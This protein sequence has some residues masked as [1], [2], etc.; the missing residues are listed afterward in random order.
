MSEAKDPVRAKELYKEHPSFGYMMLSSNANVSP[1]ETQI[2][3]Q[4]HENQDGTG[5]PTGLRGENLPP[6][7]TVDRVQKGHI[8]RLAE[9]CS[10][11]NA[12]DNLA[13]NPTERTPRDSVDAIRTII[14]K[15]GTVYNKDVVKTLLSVVPYY[16]VGTTVKVMDIVDPALVGAVGVVAK[17]HDDN[18]NKP[19][20]IL[21]KNK[22]M[23]KIKPIV[24]DTSQF[25]KVSLKLVV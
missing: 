5:F 13:Y 18:I 23:K 4:H 10:V 11:A 3:N 24:L 22:F 12:F 9:V 1:I 15:A 2:V 17:L 19:I 20:I 8:F 25:Q 14:L 7:K 16:P 6:V 21:T